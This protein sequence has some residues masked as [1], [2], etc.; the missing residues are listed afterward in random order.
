MAEG[1]LGGG[2]FARLVVVEAAVDVVAA[3]YQRIKPRGIRANS[4]RRDA[5]AL[6]VKLV[7]TDR[8]NGGFTE[9]DL[10]GTS[11]KKVTNLDKPRMI[12]EN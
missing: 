7:T 11:D 9:H 8:V 3:S 5:D 6:P 12:I 4:R 2:R 10:A 1:H